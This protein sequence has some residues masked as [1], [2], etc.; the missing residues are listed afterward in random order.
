MSTCDIL[1]HERGILIFEHFMTKFHELPEQPSYLGCIINENLDFTVTAECLAESAER[2]LGM[3]INKFFANKHMSFQ[4]FTKLYNSC[5]CSIMDYASGVWGNK[6]YSKSDT[7]QNKAIRIFLGV[8]KYASNVAIQGDVAWTTLHIRRKLNMIRLWHRLTTMDSDRITQKIFL[9]DLNACKRGTWS[10]DMK[11]VFSEINKIDIYNNRE[12]FDLKAILKHAEAILMDAEKR[13]WNIE[14]DKQPK[15]RTYKLFKTEFKL[16]DYVH[17]DLSLS[18]RSVLAQIRC[19]ILPLRIETGRF[20]GKAEAERLCKFCD[21]NSN[22][23]YLP[24]STLCK[25]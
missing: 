21:T 25:P 6:Y 11:Q 9:W 16:E 3:L 24:V 4:T 15:L 12:S 20:E 2:A 5:I 10:Y 14:L 8:H 18:Q 17:M 1:K 23:F 22:S 19:G 13:K 7:V